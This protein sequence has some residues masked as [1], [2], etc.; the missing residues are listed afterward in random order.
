MKISDY[1]VQERKRWIRLDEKCG[2]EHDVPCHHN[3]DEFL[4]GY[5]EAAGIKDDANGYLCRSSSRRSAI[6]SKRPLS[7]PDFYRM[8]RRRAKAAGI[9]TR[10]GNHTFR[11]TGITAYLKNAGKL[12]VAQHIAYH[13]STCLTARTAW[14]KDHNNLVVVYQIKTK[15]QLISP[16]API[17]PP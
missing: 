5:I 17:T 14:S 11:A 9:A 3:L 16:P 6:L 4:D 2:K 7:Q 12:E 1:F 15:L 8:V 10:I 13:E